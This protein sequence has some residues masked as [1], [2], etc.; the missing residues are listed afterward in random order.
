MSTTSR[1]KVWINPQENH[2]TFL[3]IDEVYDTKERVKLPLA[4]PYLLQVSTGEQTSLYPLTLNQ[5][6]DVSCAG[7]QPVQKRQADN[8]KTLKREGAQRKI[9]FNYF[10]ILS[11]LKISRPL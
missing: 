3:L 10:V 1:I 5:M 6:V 2:E 7:T 11:K 8:D 4:H 9:T